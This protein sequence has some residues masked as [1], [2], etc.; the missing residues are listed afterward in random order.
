MCW[1]GVQYFRSWSIPDYLEFDKRAEARS[2][3][4][5][6]TTNIDTNTT[7]IP[8]WLIAVAMCFAVFDVWINY[9]LDINIFELRLK[10][11]ESS[12]WGISYRLFMV[13][14]V[15]TQLRPKQWL[16]VCV[17][18]GSAV[19]RNWWVQN[20]YDR[21]PKWPEL[22]FYWK[23]C[24]KAAVPFLVK[25]SPL[26]F[27]RVWLTL[28]SSIKFHWF[29]RGSCWCLWDLFSCL[30]AALRGTQRESPKNFSSVRIS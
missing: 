16:P 2:W 5:L 8:R 14:H 23:F 11:H 6:S 22:Y 18:R 17:L 3:N 25:W 27:K 15:I 4:S 1:S 21:T 13:E 26:R 19:C 30:S 7:T 28:L 29:S 9:S 10:M 20:V 12:T 24:A